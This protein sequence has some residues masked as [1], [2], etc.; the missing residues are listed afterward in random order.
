M[1]TPSKNISTKKQQ[2]KKQAR[3]T[4]QQSLYVPPQ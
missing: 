3:V 1:I 2:K 4:G